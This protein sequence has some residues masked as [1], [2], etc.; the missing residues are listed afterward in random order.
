MATDRFFIGPINTGLQTDV[1]SWAL[2]ED[3][4]VELNNAYVFRGRVKKRFGTH[5]MNTSFDK[6]LQQFYTRLRI[7]I[8]VTD[9]NGD[10]VALLT[11]PGGVYAIGQAFTIGTELFTVNEAGT[12]GDMLITGASTTHTYDTTTGVVVIKGAAHNTDIYFYPAL[13]VMGLPTYEIGATNDNPVVAF[14]TRFSYEYISGAWTALDIANAAAQWSGADDDFFWAETVR[15]LN[16][17]LTIAPYLFVVNFVEADGIRYYD[18][19][20]WAKYLPFT[21]QYS[22]APNGYDII[23]ARIVLQ[24]HGRLLFFNTIEHV[25]GTVT[26]FPNRCR[27]SWVGDFLSKDAGNFQ[28][29]RT[30][31]KGRGGAISAATSEAIISAEF[32][33]DRLIVFFERSTWELVYTGN[34]IYP[35]EWQKLDTTLGAEATFSTVPFDKTIYTIGNV[36]VHAC[37]G[38]NIE[39][40]DQKIPD[41][42]KQIHNSNQGIKR[43][44]G[45]RDYYSEMIYWALP[46]KTSEVFPNKVLVYNYRNNSWAFNDDTITCFG[47]WQ[48]STALLWQDVTWQWQNWGGA[49]DDGEALAQTLQIIAGNQQGF[50]F[51][52][53]PD[54]PRNSP[55]LQIT[56]WITNVIYV[57]D[58]NVSAGD[59]LCI[60]GLTDTQYTLVQVLSIDSSDPAIDLLTITF[61]IGGIY[62]GGATAAKVSI[63]DILSKQYGFYLNKDRNTRVHKVNFLVDKTNSG[64]ILVDYMVSA[65]SESELEQGSATGTLQGTGVLQTCP[66]PSAIAGVPFYP[67]ETS[68]E[69]LWHFAYVF[70]EGATVQLHFYWSDD[71]IEASINAGVDIVHQP[72]ELHAMVFFAEPT[73]MNM[74]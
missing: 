72:F 59:W 43:V 6:T 3:A 31:I 13:P 71:E 14:D 28:A 65:S 46:C 57:V 73:S 2:P 32:L 5:V 52:V 42:V 56:D 23:A 41:F 45:I 4:F 61:D 11:V 70:A 33:K 8:G 15:N 40:I 54:M 60:E 66:Y 27:F 9:N 35:F 50:V 17:N 48:Q 29:F 26:D 12:P 24:F 19:T 49:W 67:L 7:K 44:Y 55:S 58:S 38:M 68:Q 37:N 18:G 25:N 22:A 21:A 69:R 63:V 39:R 51:I 62:T 20:V 74:Y 53:D 36:G 34:Q 30:D 16:S 47:Y 64:E 10:T 1:K